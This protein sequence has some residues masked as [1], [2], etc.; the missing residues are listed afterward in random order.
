MII[1]FVVF[2]RILQ[3]FLEFLQKLIQFNDIELYGTKLTST[4]PKWSKFQQH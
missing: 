4:L 2:M 3:D 1:S